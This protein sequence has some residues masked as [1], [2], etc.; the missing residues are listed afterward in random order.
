M[1]MNLSDQAL[2]IA[3]FHQDGRLRA[4]TLRF[5]EACRGIFKRLIFVSTNLTADQRSLLPDFVECHVR[6]NIG[7]DFF[8]YRLGMRLILDG[9]NGHAEGMS[10]ISLMNTSFIIS[11]HHKFINSY[12]YDGLSSLDVDFSGLTFHASDG[13]VYP[14]LQS[15]LLSVGKK[16]LNDSRFISWWTGLIPTHDKDQIIQNYEIGLSRLVD[17]LG[18]KSSPIYQQIAVQN[19]L[20]PMHGN[21]LE[22]LEKFGILKIGLFKINP[23]RLNLDPLIFRAQV[24]EKFRLLLVDGMEN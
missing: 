7:Y 11:D 22:I 16:V 15:F 17:D 19:I 13:S 12:F 6:E 18:Y 1:T 5:L 4:D 21:F 3:H 23:F 8:S 2:V 9:D 20:D 14:H 24:D 10:R